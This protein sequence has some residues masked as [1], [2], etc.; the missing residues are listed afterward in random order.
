MGDKL[1]EKY[2]NHPST[3]IAKM[4]S[5]GNEMEEIKVQGFPTIKLIKKGTNDIVDFDG[6]RTKEG[7][8]KF[9]E[10]QVGGAKKE[11]KEGRRISKAP[12]KKGRSWK[13]KMQDTK[14]G[15]R[16]SQVPPEKGRRWK[17]KIQDTK[18][19]RRLSQAP[20]E[21]GKS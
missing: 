4:D 1:E 9:L 2:A 16:I 8:V 6:E 10:A 12:P 13:A 14:D 20:P 19:G 15:Q 3:V 5:T 7:F 18:D 21:K 17:A 11:T